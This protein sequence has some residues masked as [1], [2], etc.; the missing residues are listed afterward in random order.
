MAEEISDWKDHLRIEVERTE[1]L[2]KALVVLLG[3]FDNPYVFPH[4][5]QK[6]KEMAKE[7]LKSL[8][9]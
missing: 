1:I 2:R 8:K 4:E 5:R 7:A 6:A 9:S 3:H